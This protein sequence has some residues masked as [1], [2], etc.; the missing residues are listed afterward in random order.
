MNRVISDIPIITINPAQNWNHLVSAPDSRKTLA[1]IAPSTQN[2]KLPVV[3]AIRQ[4]DDFI[5]NLIG[6]IISCSIPT[7]NM[8]SIT[9]VKKPMR[10]EGLTG[11]GRF[12]MLDS[13]K[14]I[15]DCC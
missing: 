14:M 1:S 12:R 11:A 2:T 13:P 3:S 8:K 15:I 5:N 10:Y 4:I 6:R 9:A 7:P